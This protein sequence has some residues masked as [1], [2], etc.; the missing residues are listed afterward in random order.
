MAD[1]GLTYTQ[2]KAAEGSYVFQMEP[3][4]D[5]LAQFPGYIGVTLNYFSRQ[6][7]AREVELERIRRSTPR[8]GA[9]TSNSKSTTTNAAS[10]AGA[11]KDA[12]KR[13]PNHLQRLKAK[14]VDNKNANAK[15]D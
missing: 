15:R 12:E 7:V 9:E 2:V 3:D 14:Q 4:L 13:L 8:L 6:L 11:N 5:A 10:A 1:L